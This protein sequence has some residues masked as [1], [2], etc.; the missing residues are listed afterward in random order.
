MLKIAQ[1]GMT[2]RQQC[3]ASLT[4]IMIIII[5]IQRSLFKTTAFGPVLIDL[6]R[7]VAALQR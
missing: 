2:W 6:Y 3:D 1:K 5:R 7:E 4:G